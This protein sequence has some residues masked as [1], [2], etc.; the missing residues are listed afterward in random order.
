MERHAAGPLSLT[1]RL[2][3]ATSAV[4]AIRHAVDALFGRVNSVPVHVAPIAAVTEGAQ[5]RD[6]AMTRPLTRSSGL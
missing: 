3:I 6:I 5:A 4:I 2:A 1:L